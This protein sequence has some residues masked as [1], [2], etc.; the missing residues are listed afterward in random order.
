MV[1]GWLL[2]RWIW[3]IKPHMKHLV[4]HYCGLHCKILTKARLT[5]VRNCTSR[6]FNSAWSGLQSVAYQLSSKQCFDAKPPSSQ[7]VWRRLYLEKNLQIKHVGSPLGR[8]I[9][10]HAYTKHARLAFY[11]GCTYTTQQKGGLG[12]YYVFG[13][14]DNKPTQCSLT[15]YKSRY[16]NQLGSCQSLQGVKHVWYQ[17][18]IVCLFPGASCPSPRSV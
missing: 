15:Q 3:N 2:R 9:P 6:S 17:G 18:H 1:I 13:T 4:A 16:I 12:N 11:L 7:C 10:S 8:K 5:Q 14:W